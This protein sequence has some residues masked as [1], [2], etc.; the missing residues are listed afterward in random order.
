MHIPAAGRHDVPAVNGRDGDQHVRYFTT[1][2]WLVNIGD[3]Y[4]DGASL[5]GLAPKIGDIAGR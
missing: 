3:N 4:G 5:P 2:F 1:A